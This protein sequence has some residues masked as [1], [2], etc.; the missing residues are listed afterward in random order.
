M[1]KMLLVAVAICAIGPLAGPPI[2]AAQQPQ[3]QPTVTVF[4]NCTAGPAG[5]IIYMILARVTGLS[6]GEVVN[7][8]GT[9]IASDPP[10][11]FGSFSGPADPSGVALLGAFIGELGRQYAFLVSIPSRSFSVTRHVTVDCMD[12]LP[13]PVPKRMVG[14]GSVSDH[15]LN[16]AYAYIL[17]CDARRTPTPASRH[18]QAETSFD[19]PVSRASSAGMTRPSR[20]RPP[21]ST[22]SGAPARRR[23]T[24]RPATSSS[25]SSSTAARRGQRL[26]R[27]RLTGPSGAVVFR[28]SGGAAR[29]FPGSDQPTGYNTA[30]LA[31]LARGNPAR[32]YS[33]GRYVLV[34]SHPRLRQAAI[35]R[36][37]IARA[38][39]YRLSFDQASP[40]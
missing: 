4:E 16:A 2:V 11:A 20:P 5:S 10:R 7:V 18:E 28:G 37:R 26:R 17:P 35:R 23:S 29:K 22:P 19:S 24:E 32:G 39:R 15:G 40:R 36:D 31:A 8:S 9:D 27:A 1:K 3:P 6:P 33:A 12:E 38:P 21:A 25:G 13:V 34:S 14:K 30:Q